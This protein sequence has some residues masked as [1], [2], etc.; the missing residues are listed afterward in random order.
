MTPGFAALAAAFALSAALLLAAPWGGRRI[1]LFCAGLAAAGGLA[2]VAGLVALWAE[3]GVW[4]LGPALA[5]ALDPL[6]GWFL[7]VAGLVVAIAAP[8]LAARDGG[9]DAARLLPL[10]AFVAAMLLA[11]AAADGV[12]LLA[13][14]GGMSLAAA[15]LL[16]APGPGAR[17]AAVVLVGGTVAGGVALAV[18][19]GLLAGTA[20]GTGFDRLRALPPEGWRAAAVLALALLGLALMAGVLPRR[21]WLPR[22]HRVAPAP[23]SALLSGATA[24]VALGVAARVLVDLSGPAQPLWWGAAA[25]ALGAAMAV[26]GALRA[27]LA[28]EIAAVAA[29]AAIGQAGMVVV[30]FGLAACF[31]AADLQAL[32]GLVLAAGLLQALHQALAQM[33]LALSA[34]AV[35][36]EGGSRRLDRLGGLVHAM[37]WTAALTLAGAASVASLPLSAGFAS[38]W[39]LLQALLAGP[40][41]G[42][43]WLQVVMAVATASLGLGAA[44][45]AAAMLRACGLLF[46]GRPRTPRALGARDAPLPW[47]LPMAAAAGLLLL[48]GLLPGATL[49]A[50]GAVTGWLGLGA[51]AGGQAL[52]LAAPGAAYLPLPLAALLA[53]VGA[54]AWLAVGRGGRPEARQGRAWDG[55]AA[56]PPSWLPLGDPLTQPSAAGFAEPLRRV[57][58]DPWRRGQSAIAAA[59]PAARLAR[60]ARDRL[61]ALGSVARDHG[62]G[63]LILG[64][65]LLVV[66]VL[67]R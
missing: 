60:A 28:E 32:A 21:G 42:A 6:A 18:A 22:L 4:R 66:V 47:R 46:L 40:R 16:L 30:A 53:A 10:P 37:P 45:A 51:V 54:A 63:P 48:A 67:A 5:L 55:G 31:R 14:V 50:A 2:V 43:P 8:A 12:T 9:A 15:A 3:P 26:L 25:L 11:L 39:L 36:A 24:T 7:I 41:I 61:A 44:L 52:G 23:V 1:G 59:R 56:P 13:G 19:L 34:G 49:A 20:G 58:A 57:L 27:L 65:L 29:A 64:V 35:A 33:L 62:R 38:D 17:R